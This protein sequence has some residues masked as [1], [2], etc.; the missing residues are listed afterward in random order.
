MLG[1]KQALEKTSTHLE[2]MA[3][4][5]HPIKVPLLDPR[6]V[7]TQVTSALAFSFPSS[8]F[9]L[10]SCLSFQKRKTWMKNYENSLNH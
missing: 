10:S 9:C 2:Q 8:T 3:A 7:D 4:T 5:L 1:R 6:L